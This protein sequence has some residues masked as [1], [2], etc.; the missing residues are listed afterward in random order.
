MENTS[1]KTETSGDIMPYYQEATQ[2]GTAEMHT[3]KQHMEVSGPA[4]ESELYLQSTLKH[5]NSRSGIESATPWRQAGSLTYYVTVGTPR[6]SF[7]VNKDICEDGG[8]KKKK[9]KL[10]LTVAKN[11]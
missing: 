3:L 5:N 11:I 4:I 9:G 8:K 1:M 6:R 7:S 2:D 10:T